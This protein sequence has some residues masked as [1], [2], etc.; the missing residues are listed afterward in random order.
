[1]KK[2]IFLLP[3]FACLSCAEDTTVDPTLMPA[4]TSNGQ[5]T[6]GCLVDGWVYTSGRFGLPEAKGYVNESNYY[7]DIS[8]PVGRFSNIRFTL[9][10]PRVNTSCAYT[11]ATLGQDNLPVGQAFIT[12][13][14][15]EII[16]GTFE[17][18]NLSQ[19][20]FDIKYEAENDGGAVVA[21]K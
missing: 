9:V 17:G 3:L 15:G 16:S 6:F 5:N 12:R 18:G 14:D 20:R 11:N 2:V 7:V 19:G 21:L 1:M 4:A 10:N 8:A 13:N